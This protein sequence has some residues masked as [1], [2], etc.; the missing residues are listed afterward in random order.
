MNRV[1][2]RDPPLSLLS[3]GVVNWVLMHLTVHGRQRGLLGH[4]EQSKHDMASRVLSRAMG[5][6]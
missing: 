1:N 6:E 2:R 5:L 4:R 3:V